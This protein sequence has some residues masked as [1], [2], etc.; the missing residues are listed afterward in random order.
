MGSSA[1][2][3]ACRVPC[4]LNFWCVKRATPTAVSDAC[5]Q[6]IRWSATLGRVDFAPAAAAAAAAAI[7]KNFVGKVQHNVARLINERARVRFERIRAGQLEPESDGPGWCVRQHSNKK[8]FLACNLIM[9]YLRSLRFIWL[10]INLQHARRSGWRAS[11]R[12]SGRRRTDG[13]ELH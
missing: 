3:R 5:V 13:M 2:V 12:R 9:P 1:S 10:H 8:T 6:I 4:P 11:G 7:P